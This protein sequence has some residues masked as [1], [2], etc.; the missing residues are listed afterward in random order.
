MTV[1]KLLEDIA[2]S[3]LQVLAEGG[4]QLALEG[5]ICRF[6]IVIV[7]FPFSFSFSFLFLFLFLSSFFSFSFSFSFPFPFP[8]PFRYILLYE[9]T[10]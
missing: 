8:Y 10:E 2:N 1:I 6:I 3:Y 7:N 4:I 9:A 5:K